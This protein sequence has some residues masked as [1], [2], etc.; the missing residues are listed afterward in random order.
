MH[1]T[2]GSMTWNSMCADC[3]STNLHKNLN[4]QS[5]DYQTQYS[6]I[7]VSCEACHGPGK[8]HVT[9][10]HRSGD[11]SAPPPS[12][13][14]QTNMEARILVDRCA[15]CHSRRSM[16]TNYF[17]YT[18][19]YL[20]HYQPNLITTPAYERDGQIKDEDYVYGS[21]LQSVMYHRGVSC[22][23][24]HQVHSLRLKKQGNALCLSCHEERFDTKEHHM[25]E[26]GTE[27]A[28]CI[29]CHMPGKFYMG[30][31]FRRDHSFRVPRPDQSVR[32]GVPNACSSCH[33]EGAQWATEQIRSHTKRPP[34]HHFSDDLLEA[35]SGQRNAFIKL[36]SHENPEIV[37]A[38]G[39]A[40]FGRAITA[41]EEFDLIRPYCNDSSALVRHQ[42]ALVLGSAQDTIFAQDLTRMLGDS[43][44][45]VR[46]AA[47]RYFLMRG[48]AKPNHPAFYR[49]K[50]EYLR[51]LDVNADF[52]SGQHEI[53]LYFSAQ[54]Q[55]DRA[56]AA[57]EKAL[58]LDDYYN[59]S[60]INLAFVAYT[61][62]NIKRAKQLYLKVVAQEPDYSLPYYMLGLL[63]NESGDDEMTVHYLSLAC[64]KK[65][66]LIRAHYNLALKLIKM[67]KYADSRA[68]I[69]RGLARVPDDAGLLEL[70]GLLGG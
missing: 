7:N 29:N 56:I 68:V 66:F 20:D 60:R 62:G 3:H 57:Y 23:D 69:E 46:L 16:H 2:G 45:L 28:L 39:L 42:A 5:L 59:P 54:G 47:V 49:A 37:R 32:Y 40:L 30:N 12:L 9:Y 22:K 44:R 8:D 13:Y 65:P 61:R 43:V 35:Y 4:T 34:K 33:S 55:E 10:Y 51:S 25:H 64:D 41:Q 1:W 11:Y 53:A 6:I 27:G 19:V 63:Y 14:M 52:A 24:C 58:E 21:F 15:R 31:D 70:V 26:T 17:G 48:I 67:K 36:L 38:S 50:A 18:G